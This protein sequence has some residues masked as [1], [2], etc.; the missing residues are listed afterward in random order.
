[1]NTAGHDDLSGW[2][3]GNT[4]L[5]VKAIVKGQGL[6]WYLW[7]SVR[8]EIWAVFDSLSRSDGTERT[9]I[10]GN[11]TVSRTCSICVG[12]KSGAGRTVTSHPGNWCIVYKHRLEI[13][14]KFV[15]AWYLLQVK[16]NKFYPSNYFIDCFPHLHLLVQ[17]YHWCCETLVIVQSCDAGI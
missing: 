2:C 17:L 1:M 7:T 15:Q 3:H 16:Y 6:G 12:R 4:V 10:K 13:L 14:L 9:A 8:S 5:N 11:A